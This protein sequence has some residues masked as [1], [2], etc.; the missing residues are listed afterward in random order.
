[1]FEALDLIMDENIA[2]HMVSFA[3]EF[4]VK[5]RRDRWIGILSNHKLK[6]FKL[7]SKLYEHLNRSFCVRNDDLVAVTTDDVVGVF[8][9]FFDAPREMNFATAK[10]LGLGSDAIF[11]IISGKHAVF[12]FHE[13]ENY[14]L[15]K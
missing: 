6:N 5:E 4:V 7:S 3:T 12:F 10:E 9:D 13:H 8:Y 1:M 11:S 2:K 15:K 14:E